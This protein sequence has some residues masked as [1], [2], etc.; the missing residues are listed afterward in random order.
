MAAA[1]DPVI[2]R[3]N[4]IEDISAGQTVGFVDPFTN[5]HLFLQVEERF[6][7]ALFQQLPRAHTRCQVVSPA[8]ALNHHYLLASLIGVHG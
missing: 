4:V 1:S 5:A 3:V 2:E 8:K 7:T 6:G